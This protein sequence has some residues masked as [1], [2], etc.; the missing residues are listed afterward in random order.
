MSKRK[1]T[2]KITGHTGYFY[3]FAIAQFHISDFRFHIHG[4]ESED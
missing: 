1:G 3:N 2:E 4:V